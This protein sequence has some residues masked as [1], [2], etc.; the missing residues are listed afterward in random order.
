MKKKN[1]LKDILKNKKPLVAYKAST[2]CKS[3]V[4]KKSLKDY[5]YCPSTKENRNTYGKFIWLII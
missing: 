3:T 4:V 1:S 5:E 2:E